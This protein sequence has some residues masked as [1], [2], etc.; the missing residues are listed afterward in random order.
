VI[1]TGASNGIGASTAALF[2]EQGARVAAL[3]IR[4][5]P[6]QAHDNRIDIKCNVANEEEVI[7]A[8]KQVVDKWGTIDVLCNVAGIADRFRKVLPFLHRPFQQLTCV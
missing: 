1:I 4:D 7:A 5:P 2:E 6:Q 8:V 3:D